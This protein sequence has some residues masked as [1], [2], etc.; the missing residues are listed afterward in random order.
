METK[1]YVT[2]QSSID[3]TV[4]GGLQYQDNTDTNSQSPDKLKISPSWV[5]LKVDVKRGKGLYPAEI[6]EWESVKKLEKAEV[7]TVGAFVDAPENEEQEMIR[8]QLI[9]N[10]GEVRETSTTPTLKKS[11]R[12]LSEI[13]N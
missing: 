9:S 8:K 7:L 6:A 10:I 13:A 12:K 1:K 3:I 11:S 2:I 5:K 4:T